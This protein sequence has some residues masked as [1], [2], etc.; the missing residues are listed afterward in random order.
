MWVAMAD[1]DGG[2]ILMWRKKAWKL[3]TGSTA[4]VEILTCGRGGKGGGE[5]A[6][7]QSTCKWKQGNSNTGVTVRKATFYRVIVELVC[8]GR[9]QS[10]IL[11][12]SS[13]F[14]QKRWWDRL[15]C[16]QCAV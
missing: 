1:G 5:W 12:N 3:A 11:P 6:L 8:C 9:C 13:M 7:G 4:A 10:K 16:K 14:V 15:V 2:V